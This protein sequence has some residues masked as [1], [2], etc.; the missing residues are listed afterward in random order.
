MSLMLAS[1]AIVDLAGGSDV[2]HFHFFVMVGVVALYQ[3]W[4][5]FGVCILITVLHHAVLGT[6]DP[7]AVYGSS[8]ERSNPIVWSLVHGAFVLAAS[9]TH[10]IA[11]RANER[12]ELSDPLTRLPNRTAFVERLERLSADPSIPISVCFVDI[13]NFKQINDSAGHHVG[14]RALCHVADQLTSVMRT[15][16]MVARLGG[17]EFAVFVR[18]NA[19]AAEALAARLLARFERPMS[20]EGH[21]VV[22]RASI[23][24]ADNDLAGSRRP[25]DLLR[26]A[27]VAMYLAKSSGKNRVVTYTAGVD[28]IVRDRAELTSDLRF[29]L[30]EEQLT[31]HYQPVVAGAHGSLVGVEALV[32]WH[33]PVRGLIPPND[34][35]PL[36]E[37]TGDI[38]EIGAWVLRHAAAQVVAWQ[39]TLSGCEN[40]SLAVNLSPVQLRDE[41]LVELVCSALMATSLAPRHLTLEVTESMLLVDLDHARGQL[42]ALRQLGVRIAIDDFGTGYSSLSYLSSL[43]ADVIKIDRSFVKDLEAGSAPSVLVQAVVDMAQALDLGVVAEGVENAQ[44]QTVLTELGCPHSQGYLYSPAVDAPDFARLVLDWPSVAGNAEEGHPLSVTSG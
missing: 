16:D 9:A 33:H 17:D 6:F 21:Q 23:G 31:I 36:A 14:D 26:D 4:T 11:W 37:E 7:T 20:V 40:L 3:D 2:A 24:V 39:R 35:I 18:G 12:Q 8:T 38:R 27:D 28:Q 41:D 42:D 22:L 5:A 1:T 30:V 15:G 10:L 32:R 29:A 13:D 19:A 43:P 25:E 44:Q 34:F